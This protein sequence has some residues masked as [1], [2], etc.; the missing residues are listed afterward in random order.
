MTQAAHL[1]VVSDEDA[2][3]ANALREKQKPRHP[4]FPEAQRLAE[5]VEELFGELNS[6]KAILGDKQQS[7][8]SFDAD[9]AQ[10]RAEMVEDIEERKRFINAL[11]ETRETLLRVSGELDA[12]GRRE[13]SAE[14]EKKAPAKRR[15][16]AE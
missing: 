8:K 14:P 4:A 7:L 6:E 1:T 3:L 10:K 2:E 16:A 13:P 11:G 9:V 12:M 5:R 15:A